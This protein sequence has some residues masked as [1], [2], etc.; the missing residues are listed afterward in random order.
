MTSTSRTAT[1]LNP[2]LAPITMAQRAG[3]DNKATVMRVMVSFFANQLCHLPYMRHY[4][5]PTFWRWILQETRYTRNGEIINSI[6]S[7]SFFA[8]RRFK[9]TFF[10]LGKVFLICIWPKLVL[11][12]YEP[13]INQVLLTLYGR[14]HKNFQIHSTINTQCTFACFANA[15]A[16]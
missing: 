3:D 2:K 10:L 14:E 1:G 9:R 6:L 12:V 7:T 15:R 4:M 11:W 8:R 13:T 5:R 16:S